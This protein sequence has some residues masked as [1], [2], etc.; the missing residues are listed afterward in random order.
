[1]KVKK[2]LIQV[3]T[4]YTNMCLPCNIHARYVNDL[5]V[6]HGQP[7]TSHIS[8]ENSKFGSG[9]NLMGH[10]IYLKLFKY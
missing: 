8:T 3:H 9:T 2:K 5:S 1:M 10:N 7:Q 4:I 6:C